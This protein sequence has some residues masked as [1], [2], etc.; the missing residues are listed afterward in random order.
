VTETSHASPL[1][2]DEDARDGQTGQP[3][4]ARAGTFALYGP[5]FQT[6]LAEL[7]REM[8]RRHG[9]VAPVLLEGDVP[10]WLVLGYREV[11]YVTANTN[12]F[13]RDSRRWNQ[14]PRIPPDWPLLPLLGPQESVLDAEGAE[15]RRRA[16]AIS[17][18]LAAVDPFELRTH[19]ERV[20]DTLID[21]FAGTGEADLVADYANQ[22]PL[23]VVVGLVGLAES[24]GSSL[25]QDFFTMV[26]G[27]AD[28]LGADARNR[29]RMQRLL[30][31]KRDLPGSDV[32]T[33][34]ISH[35]A[36]LSDKEIVED[37]MAV[38]GAGQV[39]TS[40][41]I[42]NTLRLMLTDDRFALTLSGGRRSIG[43]A[44]NEVLWADTPTQNFPGRF[45]V[46]DTRLGGQHIKT[47]DL[48]ILGLAAANNDPHVRPNPTAYADSGGNQAH[49]SFSQGDH[50]C[51]HAA[52][53]LAEVITETAIEVLLDRLPDL[54]LAVAKE[55]LVW[56]PSPWMRGLV[57]LPVRFT[58]AYISTAR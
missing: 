51:P 47:G 27:G 39:H 4:P 43:Q 33:R 32:A 8:R 29:A 28:A 56:S 38:M 12:L 36:G 49:L 26:S 15:H 13:G 34:L 21:V 35:Q 20:C 37:L 46:R 16:G 22:I 5:R 1:P 9:A 2:E 14:W 30:D 17:D 57:A 58:P 24:E 40:C 44:L 7:Y 11:H 53:E 52:Q 48:L 10:A 19:C 42:G 41:W 31:L 54:T 50:R 45:A 3:A 25:M 18:A 6:D 23:R 55:A